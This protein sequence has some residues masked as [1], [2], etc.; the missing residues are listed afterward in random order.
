MRK[1]NI[2]IT[3]APGIGKTTL[4]RK[5]CTACTGFRPQGFFT[6]EIRQMG[7][8]VG[9][10]LTG[11][12]GGEQILSHIALRGRHRVGKYGVD[13]EGFDVFIRE[14]LFV[15]PGTRLF[16]IDEIGK[17]ECISSQFRHCVREI[18]DAEIPLVATISLR[19]DAGI[20][21]VK[22]RDD[23]L[24]YQVTRENRD[25][26]AGEITGAVRML[27]HEPGSLS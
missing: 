20:D 19:G 18:L 6:G 26:L 27:M 9:F 25:T 11:L 4:F 24:V 13:I 7:T 21:T 10:S 23:V 12:N 3:G 16:M 14:A 22:T 2:L 8:R 17:M 15:L 1:K 5:V